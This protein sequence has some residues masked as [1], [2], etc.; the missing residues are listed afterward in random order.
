MGKVVEYAQLKIW[1]TI[2][3]VCG[4]FDLKTRFKLLILRKN[5]LNKEK[6]PV[7]YLTASCIGRCNIPCLG[8]GKNSNFGFDT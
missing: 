2:I 7:F 5:V 8:F 1:S 3:S 4:K 6:K